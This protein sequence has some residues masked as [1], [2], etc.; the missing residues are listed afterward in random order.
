MHGPVVKASRLSL[1]HLLKLTYWHFSVFSVSKWHNDRRDAFTRGPCIWANITF[2]LFYCPWQLRL[3][4]LIT[5][6]IFY[7]VNSKSNIIMF[8]FLLHEKT[9]FLNYT[10]INKKSVLLFLGWA[11]APSWTRRQSSSEEIRKR[12]MDSG[13]PLTL[14]SFFN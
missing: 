7:S 11:R 13:I 10:K 1:R 9:L 14:G 5:Q 4:Q 8:I 3:C 6:L 2:L 12:Y